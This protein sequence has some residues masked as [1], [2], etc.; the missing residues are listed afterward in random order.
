MLNIY[1]AL[2]SEISDIKN[3]LDCMD[4]ENHISYAKDMLRSEL[5]KKRN[6]LVALENMDIEY[7]EMPF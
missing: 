5:M 1:N 4:G 7:E 6:R 3:A 2:L